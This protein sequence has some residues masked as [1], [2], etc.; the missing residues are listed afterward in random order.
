MRWRKKRI[1]K[2]FEKIMAGNFPQVK[3]RYQTIDQVFPKTTNRI[4]GGEKNPTPRHIIFKL[5]K[6]KKKIE[7]ENF[8]KEA[9]GGGKHIS[10]AP[11]VRV[12]SIFFSET[13]QKREN[14]VKYLKY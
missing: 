3:A 7:E 1:E 9:R 2:I 4:N 12:T 8:L 11:K 13:M 14:V 10:I 5:Q 6:K